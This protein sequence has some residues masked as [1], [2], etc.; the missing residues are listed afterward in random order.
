MGVIRVVPPMGRSRILAAFFY[1]SSHRFLGIIVAERIYFITFAKN[2]NEGNIMQKKNYYLDS[3]LDLNSN[4][5]WGVDGQELL[6]LWQKDIKE[7]DKIALKRNEKFPQAIHTFFSSKKN[8][9]RLRKIRVLS[10]HSYPTG[11]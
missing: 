5:V 7:E 4:N 11:S 6:D 9:N 8:V 2:F 10:I 1:A 3:V